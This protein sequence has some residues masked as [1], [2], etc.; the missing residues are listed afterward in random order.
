M[1]PVGTETL[2]ECG[3]PPPSQHF[4]LKHPA[5]F[6]FC[7]VDPRQRLR[8]NQQLSETQTRAAWRSRDREARR[9]G[10]AG[11]RLSLASVE[12]HVG[13]CATPRGSG[14]DRAWSPAA[15]PRWR[16]RA[17]PRGAGLAS[18]PPVQRAEV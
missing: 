10:R 8:A 17:G 5:R 1:G 14:G 7:T 9:P 16:G 3:Q 15:A 18:Q 2:T 6:S 4:L 11:L 13:A 12:R